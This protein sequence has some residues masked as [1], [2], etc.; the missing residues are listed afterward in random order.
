M[1]LSV[2]ICEAQTFIRSWLYSY[3]FLEVLGFM[4]K[5]IMQLMR[6]CLCSCL[7][8]IAIF[9]WWGCS[10]V[11][12]GNTPAYSHISITA[13]PWV[14]AAPLFRSDQRWL[15]GD[16]AYSI[17]LGGQR[18]L[19]LFGDS[20]IDPAATGRRDS[21]VV[22]RN[23]LAIQHGYDPTTASMIFYWGNPGQSPSA[24]FEGSD[25]MWY[26]P[27]GGAR[28][29]DILIIF[30]M[31]IQPGDNEL[32]FESA[33]FSA[34]FI[35]NPDS[36]PQ[37]W[38]LTRLRIPENDFK[39]TL[40]SASV[41]RSGEYLYAFGTQEM[42]RNVYLV[43]WKIRDVIKKDL[44]DMYWWSAGDRA[45]VGCAELKEKPWP[46]FTNG[47]MEFTVHY[48]PSIR[49]FLQVQTISL[50]DP[51]LG[52]R[53]AQEITGPWSDM[54][55]FFKPEQMGD[56]DLLI[57]A[58]KAHHSLAGA[59]LV[60]TYAVNSTSMDRLNLDMDIY[61]PVFVRGTISSER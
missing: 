42:S 6:R 9:S 19:W 2:K 11:L 24:F 22:V 55:P 44:M 21:A 56:A 57:Y 47:Q 13:T 38:H 14:E 34:V 33:G 35:E 4:N 18:V 32:G 61:Y 25:S 26:W 46:L 53:T 36:T 15:G 10:W 17:D 45:W 48:E 16:G 23:S 8:V 58:G 39:V 59:D 31:K 28:V 30:L 41:F 60:F 1:W 3:A 12:P 52:F 29:G 49:R 43:R 40:G 27:G 7:I 50:A 54:E 51:R 20:F 5:E 37:K